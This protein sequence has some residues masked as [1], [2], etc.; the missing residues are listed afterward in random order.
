M[1]LLY[2][3][4]LSLYPVLHI[5]CGCLSPVV[6]YPL[7]TLYSWSYPPLLA[8]NPVQLHLYVCE[9]LWRMSTLRR[10]IA[11]AT[12]ILE[13]VCACCVK[14]EEVWCISVC[15]CVFVWASGVPAS[16]ILDSSNDYIDYTIMYIGYWVSIEV[17]EDKCSVM[18]RAGMCLGWRGRLRGG[19]GWRRALAPSYRWQENLHL[20]SSSSGPAQPLNQVVQGWMGCVRQTLRREE[21]DPGTAFLLDQ[22]TQHNI[23]R[24]CLEM[25]CLV[26]QIVSI[27][28][29]LYNYTYTGGTDECL[30]TTN[31]NYYN[32][33]YN[34]ITP[35]I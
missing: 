29:A 17:H 27:D 23:S 3:C 4:N 34:L 11:S 31:I 28:V 1:L 5:L 10:E 35:S 13:T 20:T 18:Y 33:T 26:W 14:R 22:Q 32:Y 19:R 12:K 25:L 7:S 9:Y 2:L 24:L 6:P 16:D 8:Y 30:L 15:M 21:K